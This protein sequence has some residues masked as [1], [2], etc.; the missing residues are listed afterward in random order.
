MNKEIDALILENIEKNSLFSDCSGIVL[1]V[2]GGSDSMTLLDYFIRKVKDIPFVVAHINHGI[3]EESDDEEEFVRSYCYK[4]S[5]PCEVYKA[6]I[7]GTKP[8]GASTEEYARQVRYGFFEE[9]KKKYGF[10]HIA[11]AHNRNDATESFFLSIVR[12][13]GMKGAA[14]IPVSRNDGVIR[15]LL[16]CEKNDILRHCEKNGI[17]YVTDKTNFESICTRNILRND[18]L[19]RLREINP[20]LDDAVFR[21]SSLAQEDEEYFEKQV[22]KALLSFGKKRQKN[23]VPLNFLRNAEKPVVSRLLRMVYSSLNTRS[24]LTFRQTNDII[25]LL[26]SGSTSDRVLIS[27]GYFAVLGYDSLR[28]EKEDLSPAPSVSAQIKEGE[29]ICGGFS[30]TLK[31]TVVTKE[32]IKSC[33]CGNPP[34]FIRSRAA[35]DRI[36]LYGRPEKSIRELF[37]DEKIP[38][39]KRPSMLIVTDSEN[40]PIFLRNFGAGEGAYV[41]T[42]DTAWEIVIAENETN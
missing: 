17:P 21:L 38:S 3:R 19:P 42:G 9:V 32:N 40:R 10:S 7:P 4:Y 12:G 30:V 8:S 16:L 33:F 37:I 26:E 13:A 36:R 24:G 35:S 15:P 41:K 34:F 20:R 39:K 2:S 14:S 23:E 25:F 6:D 28:F 31:K 1:A 29:N 27:D 22:D 11:T 5:V 18:V